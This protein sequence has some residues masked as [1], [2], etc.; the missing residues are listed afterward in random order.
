MALTEANSPSPALDPARLAK[1]FP[2]SGLPR[3]GLYRLSLLHQEGARNVSLLRFLAGSPSASIV[4]MLAGALTLVWAGASGGGT[5]K[6]DFG[7]TALV[8]LGVIAMTRNFIR[9]YARSLRRLPLAEA[10]ADLRLLLFYTGTAWGAGAFLVMPT[11][12]AP[13]LVFFFAVAP[14]LGLTLALG[15]AK[16]ALAFVLPASLTTAG[17]ALFSAWPLAGWVAGAVAMVCGVPILLPM[18]RRAMLRP[19]PAP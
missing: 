16:G 9:G 6:A 7:W 13:A 2:D 3:D 5:L 4:L 19:V 12:P 1:T 8:L 15:D 14:S 10:V 17:A 18:L 11:L